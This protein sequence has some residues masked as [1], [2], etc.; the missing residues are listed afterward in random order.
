[1]HRE[2]YAIAEEVASRLSRSLPPMKCQTCDELLYHYGH[3]VQLFTTAM[4]DGGSLVR[5][6]EET[7]DLARKCNDANDTLM[8]HLCQD[9]K[10][11]SL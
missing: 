2:L 10:A 3:A 6:A 11:A 1:M 5:T 9:H 8:E 7:E 4:R